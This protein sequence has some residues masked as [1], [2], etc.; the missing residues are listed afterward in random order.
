MSFVKTI[1]T[2]GSVGAVGVIPTFLDEKI[3]ELAI[4]GQIIDPLNPTDAKQA[5]AINLVR[6][7]YFCALMLS[8]ANCDCFSL[9]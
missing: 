1:E 2:Y 9:L 8:G 7:E 5:M 3:K 4:K 6:G